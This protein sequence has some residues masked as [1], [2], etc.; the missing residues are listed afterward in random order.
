MTAAAK[1]TASASP[2]RARAAAGLAVVGGDRE[3]HGGDGARMVSGV[4]ERAHEVRT[5]ASPYCTVEEVA[6]RLRCSI[7]TVH[8]WTRTGAIPHRRLPGSRRCLF[9]ESELE[10]WEAGAELQVRELARGGRIVEVKP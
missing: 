9:L 7:A 1:G 3:S 8:E 2:A 6:E 10:A 5:P 4:A